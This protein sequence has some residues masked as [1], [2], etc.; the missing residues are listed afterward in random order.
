MAQAREKSEIVTRTP[1]IT[2]AVAVGFA[3]ASAYASLGLD[4]VNECKMVHCWRQ[5][6]VSFKQ[7]WLQ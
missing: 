3:A 4:P 2:A 6:C 7:A 1:D 5:K